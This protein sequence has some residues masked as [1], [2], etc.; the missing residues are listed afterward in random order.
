MKNISE[1]INENGPRI[2]ETKIIKLD[3]GED[4]KG[5]FEYGINEADRIVEIIKKDIQ[6]SL[7]EFYIQNPRK[8]SAYKNGSVKVNIVFKEDSEEF[9]QLFKLYEAVG[10][11][12]DIRFFEGKIANYNI[13]GSTRGKTQVNDL[14]KIDWSKSKFFKYS[15]K[16]EKCDGNA[17][18]N[19]PGKIITEYRDKLLSIIDKT[20]ILVKFND[21]NNTYN[22]IISPV[23]KSSDLKKLYKE[24]TDSDELMDYADRLDNISKGIRDYYASKKS[25]DYTGD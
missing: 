7:Q 8:H 19:L 5:V 4:L 17:Y 21:Y 11:S 20:Q 10:M 12:Y 2:I 1:I 9:E 16:L 6:K 13:F 25:G 24:I 23:F 15:P 3:W 22:V 14:N 18:N